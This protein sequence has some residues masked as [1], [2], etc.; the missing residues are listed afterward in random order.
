MSV[1]RAQTP[2]KSAF[3]LLQKGALALD[4]GRL[5]TGYGMGAFSYVVHS[6]S[7]CSNSFRV[8]RN[9]QLTFTR[10]TTLLWTTRYRYL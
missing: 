1:F 7:S 4:I 8:I 3:V 6:L 9:K 2:D 5:A 10:L